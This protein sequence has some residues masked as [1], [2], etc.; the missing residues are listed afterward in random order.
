[1]EKQRKRFERID[2]PFGD[3]FQETMEDSVF[4]SVVKKFDRIMNEMLEEL[5]ACV[6]E[7]FRTLARPYLEQSY[8]NNIIILIDN[9]IGN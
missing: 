9:P 1:V 6:T 7:K 4:G 2:G 3:S 8:D 5:I